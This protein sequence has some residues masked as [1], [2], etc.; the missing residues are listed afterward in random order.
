M[1][2]GF[3]IRG[4]SFQP[5]RNGYARD[6]LVDRQG[7]DP[8]VTKALVVGP[9]GDLL[10]GELTRLGFDV[11]GPAG[12]DDPHQ[13][14]LGDKDVD[15]AYY[16]DTFEITDDLDGVVAEAARVVRDGGTVLYDTVNRTPLSR[17]LY[18]GVMQ[19][20]PGTRIFPRGRY[21]KDRLRPPADVAAALGR[22]GL[23]NDDVRG[24]LPGSPLRLVKAMHRARK[25]TIGDDELAELSGM[26]LGP[27]GKAGPVTYLGF[28]TKT[29]AA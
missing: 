24:F 15:V 29:E 26:H 22:H 6:V 10:A 28:A 1:L 2:D 17:L 25:G 23:R 16:A 14:P 9:G 3:H 20:W 4:A 19:S 11:T 7:Y 21:A 18:L 13:L 12:L 5:V 8:A 27:E